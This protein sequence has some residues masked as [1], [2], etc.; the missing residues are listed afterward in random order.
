MIAWTQLILKLKLLSLVCDLGHV[1]AVD[2]D[3]IG[4]VRSEFHHILF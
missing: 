4:N 3:I 1:L 2:T